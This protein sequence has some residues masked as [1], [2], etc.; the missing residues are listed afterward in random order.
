[1][2][3]PTAPPAAAT[4]SPVQDAGASAQLNQA[5]HQVITVHLNNIPLLSGLS[6]QV[7]QQVGAAM[8]FRTV[9]K[10]TYVMHKGSPGDHL[11]F[12]LSGRVQVVDVTEDGREMVLA[13]LAP[14]DY[15]GEMAVIDGQPRSASVQANE[16]ALVAFLPRAQSL[17]L[18][19]TNPLVAERVMTRMAGTIRAAA[20]NRAILSIPNAFQRVYA[21][22][23]Q[24][25]KPVPGNM[26]VIAS[27]PTQQEIAAMVNTSRETVSRALQVL[28][29]K[30]VVE[31]DMRR[32]IVRQPEALRKMALEDP[33]LAAVSSAQAGQ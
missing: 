33:S 32:L 5:V 12:L 22:L 10:G 11:V 3:E 14:G 9:E 27:M 7:L 1:M 30:K 23:N 15:V 25:A 16:T 29:Q 6:P 4:P 8:Q 18:I 24:L 31:K 26:V 13:T 2:T 21:V 19:Y 28:L 20:A 17:Q